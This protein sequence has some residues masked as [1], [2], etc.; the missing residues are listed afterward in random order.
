[1]QY[2]GHSDLS[3]TEP[4]TYACVGKADGITSWRTMQARTDA[5]VAAGTPSELHAYDG[6]PTASGSVSGPS[7]RAGSR[8][9]PPSGR[10]RSM[11]PAHPLP[12]H[13]Q[14]RT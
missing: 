8:V 14:P 6:L 1:M 3:G 11:R 9:P 2:T 13:D 4:A 12:G 5:I 10:G 7:P